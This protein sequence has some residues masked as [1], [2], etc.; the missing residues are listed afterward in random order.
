MTTSDTDNTSEA[1]SE[2][3]SP[4]PGNRRGWRS[5]ATVLAL[6]VAVVTAVV[7]SVVTPLGDH[8][9]KGILGEPTCPGAACD[10]KN[11][12]S[13]KCADDAQ[14]FKPAT[15]NPAILSLRYSKT[16]QAVWAKIEHGSP[17]DQVQV[18]AVGGGERNAEITFDDDQFTQMVAVGEG[19]FQVTACAIPK[20]GG[21]STYEHYCI[22]ASEST[23][24]R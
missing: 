23:A 8:L 10:G 18:K 5:N 4:S 24:W 13:H 22:H 9:M 16:C 12:K 6:V 17:G 3:G 14:S 21:H 7:T 1:P 2:P 19:K 11:P 15:G 20:A